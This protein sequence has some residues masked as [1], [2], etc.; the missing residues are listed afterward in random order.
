MIGRTIDH[1]RILD[2]IGEGG[3]GVVY[4]ARDTH[5]DRI[6]AIKALPPG[7]ISDDG[8]RAR[9]IQEARSASALNH[10]KI[11]HIYDIA[12]ELGMDFIAMEFIDGKTLD[13]AIPRKGMRLGDVLKVA[14]QIAD[15]LSASHAAGVIHRDLKPGNVMVTQNGYV[16]IVDFGLAKLNERLGEDQ[17]TRTMDVSTEAGVLVGTFAYMSPEQAQGHTVDARSDIFSFGVLLYEMVTG[18]RAFAG[19]SR[20]AT[21]ASVL[22]DEVKPA[23]ELVED[24]PPELDRIISR[25]LR[26]DVSRRF[27][28]MDDVKV[29]LQEIR[30]ESESGT[31]RTDASPGKPGRNPWVWPAALVAVACL[32]VIAL[33]LWRGRPA[34]TPAPQTPVQLTH[35]RGLTA[36]P[37]LSADGK[38]LAFASDRDGGGNLEIYVRQVAGGQPLQ[39]THDAA[40]DYDAALSPDG[41]QLAFRSDRD[42]GGIYIV[43]ALGGEE[44]LVAAGGR[45]PRFSPD[46]Q[47][48]LYWTGHPAIT[49]RGGGK[50]FL[51]PATGG[52]PRQL[53]ATFPVAGYPVWAP[54][55]T[56]VLFFGRKILT[57]AMFDWWVVPVANDAPKQVERPEPGA[58]PE[59]W[60]ADGVVYAGTQSGDVVNLWQCP[61]REST[62]QRTREP[63]QLTSGV[64]RHT[65][66]SISAAGDIAFAVVSASNDLWAVPFDGASGKIDGEPRPLTHDDSSKLFVRLSGYGKLL[67]Y[68]S[69]RG[70]KPEIW[71]RDFQTGKE[72][73]LAVGDSPQLSRD[74]KH[75]IYRASEGKNRAN[76]VVNLEGGVPR[77]VELSEM[78]WALSSDGSK[79]LGHQADTD[80]LLSV[81]LA[82]GRSTPIV[83]SGLFPM[84]YQASFS[85][86][87]HWVAFVVKTAPDL[88]QIFVVP[89][90][91]GL[92][93]ERGVWVAITGGSSWE[94]GPQWSSKGDAL[95]FLSERDGFRCLWGQRLDSASLRP[96]G[97]P[98]AVRHFHEAQRPFAHNLTQ[99]GD[100]V[101]QVAV[102]DDKIVYNLA[103]VTGNIWMIKHA[104]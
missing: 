92:A 95:Y 48:L 25:C 28:H 1:Y 78:V 76:Y 19:H 49:D 10:P 62:L 30:E 59:L 86:D 100:K 26:K 41:T 60:A 4:K 101:L 45:R 61:L 71:A 103:H 50:V 99:P 5:L 51:V 34:R 18:H 77:K 39:V 97:P 24:V 87:D 17:T 57:D 64:G 70:G 52:I 72:K 98:F 82:S 63:K 74:G 69:D 89:Y 20:M 83:P 40:D 3:M 38:L 21:L 81:D 54:T 37:S 11:V 56:R 27:Q 35:D 102:A 46:G 6:V 33:Y 65:Q 12:N 68:Q 15:A 8:R 13:Q 36:F 94:A 96:A 43:P 7:K 85:P 104:E 22:R 73:M 16:K 90:Q 9:F 58:I 47:W 55:G 32:C 91:D 88:S 44:R 31:L 53:A 42:G 29:A 2:K 14:V 75:V 79:V 93:P 84:V 67:V 66:A 23:R 80:V